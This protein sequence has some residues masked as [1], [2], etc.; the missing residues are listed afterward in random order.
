LA[1][2]FLRT[3]ATSLAIAW[4]RFHVEVSVAAKIATVFPALMTLPITV[5][6]TILLIGGILMA[7]C[8]TTMGNQEKANDNAKH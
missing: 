3:S 5:L 1:R 2:L 8:L 7:G 6:L 4:S